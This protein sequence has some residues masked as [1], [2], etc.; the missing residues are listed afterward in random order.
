MKTCN[1]YD[2]EFLKIANILFSPEC[3]KEIGWQCFIY[4]D[5]NFIY[6]DY[7]FCSFRFD[8][9]NCY[10][11]YGYI[12]PEYRGHGEYKRLF[13]KREIICGGKLAKIQ[14]KNPI[15]KIFLI[16]NNYQIIKD[17]GQWTYFEKHL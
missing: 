10:F 3:Q 14:T 1:T 11:D 5:M 6:S 8:D 15:L 13:L 4:P 12:M 2:P 9:K 16:K 7:G 17:N